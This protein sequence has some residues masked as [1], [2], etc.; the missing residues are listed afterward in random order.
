M[1]FEE[2]IHRFKNVKLVMVI[3]HDARDLFLKAVTNKQDLVA[4]QNPDSYVTC[5]PFETGPR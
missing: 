1:S 2:I 5:G 4:S 3:R